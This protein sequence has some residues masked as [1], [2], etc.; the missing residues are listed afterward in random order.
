MWRRS[1]AVSG[2]AMPNADHECN[3]ANAL[4]R[5]SDLIRLSRQM[6]TN[7]VETTPKPPDRP[8]FADP[9]N[10]ASE[11][12]LAG[13]AFRGDRPAPAA[14][15]RPDSRDSPDISRPGGTD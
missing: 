6:G 9:G 12:G 7:R 4:P 10:P 13:A 5:H 8:A 11:L 15:F 1:L 2:R 3:S 14:A